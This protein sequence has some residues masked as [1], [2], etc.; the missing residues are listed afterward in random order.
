MYRVYFLYTVTNTKNLIGVSL[1]VYKKYI[2]DLTLFLL[3][4][5]MQ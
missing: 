5:R 1:S 4:Y 3:Q 2:Q